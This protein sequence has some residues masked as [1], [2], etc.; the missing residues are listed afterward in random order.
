MNRFKEI[1][2]SLIIAVCCQTERSSRSERGNFSLL[3]AQAKQTSA[4][5]V[6]VCRSSVGIFLLFGGRERLIVDIIFTNCSNDKRT[7]RLDPPRSDFPLLQLDAAEP[8]ADKT[9]C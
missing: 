5:I 4:E 2:I 7:F 9:K 8:A 3:S 1:I 6:A